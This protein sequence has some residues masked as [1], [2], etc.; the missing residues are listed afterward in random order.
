MWKILSKYSL[1]RTPA[2]E[3]LHRFQFAQVVDLPKNNFAAHVNHLLKC[4]LQS[5]PATKDMELTFVDG[6]NLQIDVGYFAGTW[7]V[8]DKWL[9]YEGAHENTYCEESSSEENDL[10]SCDHTVLRLWDIMISQLIATGEHPRIMMDEGWLKSMARG[11]LAQMPRSVKCATNDRKGELAVTWE[12][13]DSHQNKDKEVKVILHVKGGTSGPE[14][15][16]GCSRNVLRCASDEGGSFVLFDVTSRLT[17]TEPQCNC[18]SQLSQ[19]VSD[20][21]IFEHL[22]PDRAYFPT[23][24]RDI[25]G[26]FIALQPNPV[27]PLSTDKV[28]IPEPATNPVSEIGE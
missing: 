8:H 5:A 20:G 2:E 15:S 9:T 26:A 3:L 12:S 1:C 21:V 13:V 10:F 11:R 16:M 17:K 25:P 27:N 19:V 4:L 22:D 28:I 23:V 14:S 6:K 7:R 18:P 24:S